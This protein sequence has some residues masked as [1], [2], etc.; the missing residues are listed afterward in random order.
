MMKA[1]ILKPLVSDGK[2]LTLGSIV[3]VSGWRNA[4][5]LVAGRYI[6]FLEESAEEA[7]PKAKNIPAVEETTLADVPTVTAKPKSPAKIKDKESE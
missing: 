3:D 2:K 7:E 4:K 5:T 1:K 6:E